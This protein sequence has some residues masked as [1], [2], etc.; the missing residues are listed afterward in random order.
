MTKLALYPGTF[1]PITLGHLDVI[2]RTLGIFDEIVVGIARNMSKSTT[3]TVTERLAMLNGSLEELELEPCVRAETFTGLTVDFAAQLGA[4]S[5]V[6]GIR[7]LADFESEFQM[8]LMNRNIRQKIETVFFM[9]SE[10]YSYVSSS[11]IKEISSLGGDV[12][13][14]VT[15]CVLRALNEKLSR[16]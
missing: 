16:D 1:D 5:I 4:V 9:P 2:R 7:A 6:R 12:S 11:L 14:L 10:Q 15:R 8:T 3:F 13:N